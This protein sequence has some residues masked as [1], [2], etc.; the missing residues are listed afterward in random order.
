MNTT[1]IIIIAVLCI[2]L[3]VSMVVV[4]YAYYKYRLNLYI[5][6]IYL[7]VLDHPP[8]I[9]T[10][11]RWAHHWKGQRELH[12]YLDQVRKSVEASKKE[13][14]VFVGL[15]QDHARELIA[16]WLPI[17]EALGSYFHDYRILILENDSKDDSR[18]LL[19]NETTRN[20]KILILCDD[21]SPLNTPACRFG[22]R[23]IEKKEDKENELPNRLHIMAQLRDTYLKRI[24]RKWSTYDHMVVIDWDLMGELSIEGFFHGLGLLRSGDVDAVAVNSMYW[25]KDKKTHCVFDTFPLLSH[26]LRCEAL[27]HKKEQ[28]DKEA[29]DYYRAKLSYQLKDPLLVESAFGG[30]AL[31]NL[32]RVLE[33]Q[34]HY[35][36]PE[37]E[38]RCPIQCEH[39][40]FHRFLRV[41]IDP[42]FVFI[43]SKNLH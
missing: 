27:L 38:R 9:L 35:F 25:N 3:L 24:G 5:E 17:V 42:W 23:S 12:K 34:S 37:Q 43:L 13:R 4:L 7:Q 15:C 39:T 10:H 19:L 18:K 32:K 36:I 31:Y 11:R 6:S 21:E 16:F 1:I 26:K 20:P 33:T 41:A 14:I 30:I 29:N 40:T 28:M 2:L 22:V 8:D